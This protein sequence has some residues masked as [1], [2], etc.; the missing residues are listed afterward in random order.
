MIGVVGNSKYSNVRESVKP[1]VYEPLDQIALMS[2]SL[3]V[4]SRLPLASLEQQI[5]KL[6]A[7]AAPDFQ[8][9]NVS[10]M[11]LLRDTGIAQDRLLTFLSVLFGVL[12]TTLALVGIYGL[13]SYSVT[14]RTREIGIRMSVGAQRQQVLLLFLRESMLLVSLGAIVGLPLALI[15]SK[16]LKAF[17]YEV[18]AADPSGIGFTLLLL[19]LGSLAASFLPARRATQVNP[20]EALRYD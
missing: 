15:L 10:T 16:P 18:P 14:R 8:V 5:R 6:V 3:Q 7:S 9:A 12:G 11:E 1:I 20:V 4:R 17:L 19:A 2:A 13:I